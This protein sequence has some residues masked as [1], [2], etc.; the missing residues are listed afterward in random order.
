M[1][2][3]PPFDIE[4][5]LA[6]PLTARLATDGPTVRPV[7]YLWEDEAFWW[8]TGDWS[9]LPPRLERDPRVALVVDAHVPAT[10][11]CRWVIA[12]G[13]AELVAYDEGRARRKLRRYLGP[14]EDE[15]GERWIAAPTRGERFVRLAPQRL[16]AKDYSYEP[17]PGAPAT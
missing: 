1:H 6:R 12:H 3:P 5:F 7:W 16:L 15:W 10:G 8:L 14:R 13:A 11:E 4:A 9:R 2:A 17:P